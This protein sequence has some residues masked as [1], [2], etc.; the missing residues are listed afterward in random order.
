MAGRESSLGERASPFPSRALRE[1]LGQAGA[2][3]PHFMGKPGRLQ[4]WSWIL[5]IHASEWLWAVSAAVV[6]RHLQEP[7]TRA[8]AALVV[9]AH[10]RPLP[11]H[12]YKPLMSCAMLWLSLSN[13]GVMQIQLPSSARGFLFIFIN[14]INHLSAIHS[15]WNQRV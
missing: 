9:V 2:V 10:R 3:G 8:H 4:Q 6:V 7:G 13:H 11:T 12:P 15:H 5:V 1:C 14:S